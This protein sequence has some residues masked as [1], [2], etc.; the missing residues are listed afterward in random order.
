ML[1]GKA[2]QIR[3]RIISLMIIFIF[4]ILFVVKPLPLISDVNI[5]PVNYLADNSAD[6]KFPAVTSH[7]DN[8]LAVN[9]P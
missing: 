5:F 8:F 2:R 3:L 4:G 1:L 6:I 9:F 7:A